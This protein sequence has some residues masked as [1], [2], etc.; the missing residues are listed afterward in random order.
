MSRLTDRASPPGYEPVLRLSTRR[1]D[2]GGPCVALQVQGR[3][4]DGHELL[5]LVHGYNNHRLEAEQ[6]YDA[7]RT[8]VTV[9][10]GL[11]T[12]CELT[13]PR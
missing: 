8:T 4:G 1:D 3:G 12:T 9:Q 6:A 11:A 13:L 5:L 2:E 10:S 7:S